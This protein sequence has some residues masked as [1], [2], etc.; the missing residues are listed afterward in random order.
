MRTFGRQYTFKRC[1]EADALAI[2]AREAK[3][4]A[5]MKDELSGMPNK[6]LNQLVLARILQLLT[7]GSSKDILMVEELRLRVDFAQF[8]AG[9]EGE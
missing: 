8:V 9:E 2:E 5:A 7:D 4:L 3:E 6:R 1:T